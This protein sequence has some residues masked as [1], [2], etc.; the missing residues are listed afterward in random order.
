[1]EIDD[2]KT[3]ITILAAHAVKC[4]EASKFGDQTSGIVRGKSPYKFI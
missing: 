4:P 3:T 2:I 1:V